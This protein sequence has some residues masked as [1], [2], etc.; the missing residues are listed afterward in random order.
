MSKVASI[1]ELNVIAVM[2]AFRS[3]NLI[4]QVIEAVPPDVSKIIVVDDCCPDET[5]HWVKKNSKDA[6]VEVIRN[7]KNL[8]VGGASMVGFRRAL[9]LG[10]DI[11]VKLD[12]DGQM[13]PMEIPRLIEPIRSGRADYAKGTRFSSLED[14]QEMPKARVFGN[15]ALS[16]WNKVST[17]YWSIS[18]PTNGFIAIN[19]GVLLHLPFEKIQNRWFFESDLLFRLSVARAVVVDI[20]IPARY[21][22]EKSNLKI[23]K[24]LL[25]FMMRHTLNFIKRIFY[26]YYLRE[27]SLVSIQLPTGLLLTIGG[28]GAGL[29]FWTGASSQGSAATAG[30]VMLAVLPIM[31]GS[32]LLLSVVNLDLL[33]EPKSPISRKWHLK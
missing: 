3:R 5:G 16:L 15:A 6:R 14:L 20:P 29:A 32:Q 11:I 19:S 27:W 12:S 9:N 30:Q 13:D 22:G 2:P 26:V 8:G 24:I 25:T 33:N 7:D 18:D 17:G 28:I 1:K 4:L 31:L 21:R 23:R 10:A